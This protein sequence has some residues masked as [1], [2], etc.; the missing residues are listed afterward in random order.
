MRNTT[1]KL[2]I[3]LGL[4]A[5]MTQ[6]VVLGIDFGSQYFKISLNAPRKQFLIVE[7]TTSQRKTQNAISFY[8]GER[9]YD[10]DASNKQVRTPETS[11]VFLDKFLGALESDQE[12]FEVAK[13]YYEE[14]ALSID[15]ERK[16]VLFELKKFQL[17]DPEEILILSIEEVVGMILLSAKR[18]AEKHS[19]IQNIRDCVISVPVNWSIR[20]RTALVQAARIASLAPI[21]LI[22]DNTAAALHYG[23]HKL[24]ENQTQTV[25]FYNI[26][27]TNIQSTL[28][29]YSYVNNTSK[30]DTQTTI[31]VITVLADYGIKDVGGYAYDLTLAHYFADIID[32]LPQRKGK[33]SFRTNRRGMVKLLKE[34]NKAKE[35]LS[36]NKEMTFFSEGLLDGND[37]R[38]QIN[39]TV[40]EEKAESLLSQVTKPIEAILAKA[41][42]TIADIDV[43]ELIG[44]GIRVPKIQQILSEYLQG[45]ELGFHMNGDES[46]ALG[47]AFHAANYSASFRVKKIFLNDGYNF[48]IRIDISDT[49]QDNNSTEVDADYQ[50]YNKTY[51][52]YPAKTRFNTRKT[53][54]L[55]HDRDITIDVYAQYPEG[56]SLKLA[57]YNITNITEIQQKE[58]YKEAGKP[59]LQ[60]TFELGSINTIELVDAVAQLNIT[61]T[62]EVEEVKQAEPLPTLTD[63]EENDGENDEQQAKKE[64]QT[65]TVEK[66]LK[67]KSRIVNLELDI[68]ERYPLFRL[69]NQTQVEASVA[70]LR[71]FDSHEEKIKRLAS[72]K[73][74]LESFIYQIRDLVDDSNFQKFS[75]ESERKE[76]LELAEQ[77][78][79]WLEGDDSFNAVYEDYKQRL[80][81][82]RNVVKPIQKRM[83]EYNKRPQALNNTLNKITDFASKVSK[84]NKTMSWVTDEQKLPI[85]KLLN[86]TSSWL[87]E[88][89]E[90]QDKLELHQDPAFTVLELEMK[91][92]EIKREFD[93]IKRIKKPKEEKK[94]DK[95]DDKKDQKKDDKKEENKDDKKEEKKQEDKKEDKSQGDGNQKQTDL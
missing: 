17:S 28:V 55:K 2:I 73:N 68:Y 3:G 62:V 90:A 1:L 94:E 81:A 88:K 24:A 51:N 22:H 25:L 21:A 37:F 74:A 39:R 15:P 63:G 34:C 61:Q 40:F 27:A 35:I 72:E 60:L 93:R 84:L 91:V 45:K 86:Q 52:L 9:Q 78:N 19:E 59:K 53:I 49:Q 75:V 14:Y 92:N 13:K 30:F 31:P 95:K 18:Y 65:P 8:N 4:L 10:K 26:G 50:P 79:E 89:I 69:L 6:A 48:D 5:T 43:I 29:D 42:K 54:S 46:T 12:V 64:T 76:A 57:Q 11:F 23:I 36:A 7:N 33:P 38:A 58:L 20:Q 70:K 47:A 82:M 85:V 83:E 56:N 66:K 87:Q 16:T 77:N 41:N 67:Q 71:K 80:T 32:N 44:G